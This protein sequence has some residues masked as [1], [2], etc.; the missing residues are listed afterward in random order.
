MTHE[1][2]SE[3]A[4][5]G[6]DPGIVGRRDVADANR[7]DHDDGVAA[8]R[9]VD[10]GH[11]T[12]VAGEEATLAPNA[13]GSDGKQFPR[14]VAPSDHLSAKWKM[15]AVVIPRRKVDYDVGSTCQPSRQILV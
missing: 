4:L 8:P 5:V 2:L 6:R 7:S 13:A 11:E 14:N 3:T 15:D 9:T 12:F 1:L 10:D